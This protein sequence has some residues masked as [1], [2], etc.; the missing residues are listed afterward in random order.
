MGCGSWVVGCGLWVVGSGLWAVGSK[1]WG[2]VGCGWND[3]LDGREIEVA[4][5]VGV[6]VAFDGLAEL[7]GLKPRIL[8]YPNIMHIMHILK[9]ATG[10]FTESVSHSV[11]VSY[12]CHLPKVKV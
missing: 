5:L 3:G 7:A 6:L 1:L 12:R 9:Y 10:P 2:A 8:T 4:K 11:R